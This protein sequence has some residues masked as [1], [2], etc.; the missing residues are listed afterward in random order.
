MSKIILGLDLG[1]TSIGY[2]L[3][4]EANKQ[5]ITAGSRIFQSGVETSTSGKESSRNATRTEKRQIRRQIFRRSERQSLVIAVLQDLGWLKREEILVEAILQKN[6]YELRRKALDEKISLE[7]LGRIFIHLSKR[8]GFKSSRKSGGDDEK[9]TG[10]LFTGDSKIGKS[11]INELQEGVVKGGFRTVGEYLAVRKVINDFLLKSDFDTLSDYCESIEV[12]HHLPNNKVFKTITEYYESLEN[13]EVR[14]RNRYVLRSQYLEEFD[15]IWNAQIKFHPEIEKPTTYESVVRNNSKSRQQERWNDKN[16]YD[17]LKNYVLYFQRPLKS[18]K[19]N[20]GMCKLEPKS[21]RSPKSALIFQEY[22]IWDKLHSI[23][24]IGPDRNLD[25]LTVEEK[26]KAYEKLSINKEQ[27]IKQ[28]LKL[29]K[30]GESYTTNYDDDTKIKGNV[31]ANILINVFG[32]GAWNA[33]SQEDKEKRWKVIYD[34]EDNEWLKGYG[35]DKWGLND[36][37]AEKLTKVSFEKSYADLSQKAMNKILPNMSVKNLDYAQACVEAGYHHSKTSEIGITSNVLSPFEKRINNPIVSQGLHE[38]RKVVNTLVTEYALPIDTIRIELA[39]ELKMPKIRREN[40]NND[41]KARDREHDKIRDFL[42]GSI[43][44]FDSEYDVSRD[45]II[46][47]K[48]WIECNKKCPYTGDEINATELFDKKNPR[49]EIEHI[50]PRSKSLDDSFQN[51]TLCERG[52]NKLKGQNMPYEMLSKGLIEQHQYD[53]ILSR[54][55]TLGFTTGKLNKKKFKKFTLQEMP[56]DM[57]A[58]QLND[59]QFLSV[60]A[61][62]YLRQICGK[63]ETSM[64]SATAQLR[65]LWGLNN[66][67]NPISKVKSRDDHRHHAVDAI[68]VA[69]TDISMVQKLSKFNEKGLEH[70]SI[71]PPWSRMRLD[72]QDKMQEILISHKQKNRVRGSLHAESMYGA[73]LNKDGSHKTDEIGQKIF[74]YRHPVSWFDNSSKVLNIADKVVKRVVLERLLKLKALTTLDFEDIINGKEGK[75]KFIVPSGA[76]A[77]KLWMPNRK[78]LQIEIKNIRVHDRANNRVEIREGSGAYVSPANN[79]HIVI[80]ETLEGKRDAESVTLLE[81]ANRKNRK[82]PVMKSIRDDG[83]KVI[84]ILQNND[85]VLMDEGDFKSSEVNWRNPDY[86]ELS[87]HLYRVETWAAT[88]KQIYFRHHLVANAK[89]DTGKT[90][91]YPSSFR[92]IKVKINHIG[93][94]SPA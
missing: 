75:I 60:V 32:S 45:D 89:L 11:G 3:Y 76:F 23:R 27:T 91:K 88:S 25:A 90:S 78:D 50:L 87:K 17:F 79:H 82:E 46:K 57:V 4:D 77:E 61:K 44:G 49:F 14:I 20:I 22:R 86:V 70:K 54:A 66:V 59:T 72:V 52:F 47:Y 2:C 80:F 34:A 69:C 63:I 83:S 48:L 9:E 33:L 15:A 28:L 43:N 1:V 5:I 36:D 62:E 64:G 30:L 84:M 7:D 85:L 74:T 19:K 31:T 8:R 39:R 13:P 53:E 12:N 6:P 18:Q 73:V 58:Q 40:I 51:K 42:V 55:K 41:N 26:L 10:K 67:L 56:T 21:R 93:E 29:W 81:A 38:L 92:G 24:I 37:E 71:A 94:I 35:I 65:K 16:L 68:V